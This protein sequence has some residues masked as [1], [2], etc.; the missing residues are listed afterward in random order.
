[1]TIILIIVIR[2]CDCL[3]SLCCD[4]FH[5]HL[6][7]I[8]PSSI[9]GYYDPYG[10]LPGSRWEL[11]WTGNGWRWVDLSSL[12]GL[13]LGGLGL[14]GLGSGFG[15]GNGFGFGSSIGGSQSS[16]KLSTL[17]ASVRMIFF[18][19]SKIQFKFGHHILIDTINVKVKSH[20]ANICTFE[21]LPNALWPFK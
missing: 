4:I 11:I 19:C 10:G 8:F 1:M 15:F 20:Y 17:L 9:A 14:G 16:S 2:V 21:F 5:F 13:G 7:H 18:V 12:G 3:N 6:S